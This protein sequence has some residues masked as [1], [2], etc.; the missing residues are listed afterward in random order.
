MPAARHK[1]L[2]PFSS[3]QDVILVVTMQMNLQALEDEA[4]APALV[5]G[6]TA[7]E[8][9]DMEDLYDD[10]QAAPATAHAAGSKQRENEVLYSEIGQ[11][12]PK[13]AKA[14]KKKAKRQA[15]A[16]KAA[17]SSLA[18]AFDPAILSDEDMSE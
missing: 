18:D 8:E 12:N 10:P 9:S 4:Q 2:D 17:A 11:H 1:S 16:T 7:Q 6:G 3:K 5:P 15:A 13:A 14:H